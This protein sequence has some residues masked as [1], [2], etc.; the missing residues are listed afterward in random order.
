[1]RG[2]SHIGAVWVLLLLDHFSDDLRVQILIAH[3]ALRLTACFFSCVPADRLRNDPE[4]GNGRRVA[5]V[6]GVKKKRSSRRNQRLKGPWMSVLALMA[7]ESRIDGGAGLQLLLQ[8]AKFD[9]R[10]HLSMTK[11]AA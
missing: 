7:A 4:R 2:Q 3:P 8:T 1:M 11:H 6:V 5:E 10:P 9:V